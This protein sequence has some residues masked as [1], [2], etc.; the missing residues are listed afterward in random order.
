MLSIAQMA[1]ATITAHT[2]AR[3]KRSRVLKKASSNPN[4]N[5]T[6]LDSRS[7]S[8][9]RPSTP[10]KKPLAVSNSN[11][12]PTQLTASTNSTRRRKVDV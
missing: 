1:L 4:G 5:N 3:G 10:V 7:S 11:P 2:A 6:K 8:T 9:G 12:M